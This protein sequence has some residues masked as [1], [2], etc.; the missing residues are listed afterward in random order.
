MSIGFSHYKRNKTEWDLS[1]EKDL[2]LI[3]AVSLVKGWYKEYFTKEERNFG[4][5]DKDVSDLR[6]MLVRVTNTNILPVPQNFFLGK[7]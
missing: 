1:S 6:L 3:D 7:I 5:R 4:L 2:C